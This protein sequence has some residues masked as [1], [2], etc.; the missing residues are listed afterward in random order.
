MR[1]VFSSS[2]SQFL[3]RALVRDGKAGQFLHLVKVDITNQTLP[4]V[5]LSLGTFTVNKILAWNSLNK[6]V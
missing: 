2:S 3:L 6:T 5:V 4:A 1:P